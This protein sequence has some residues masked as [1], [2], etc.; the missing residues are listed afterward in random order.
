M[1][2]AASIESLFSLRWEGTVMMAIRPGVRKRMVMSAGLA[3]I[4]ALA[5]LASGCGNPGEGTVH[6]DPKAAARLGKPR[7][8]PPA[9]YARNKV[10][11]IGTKSRPRKDPAPK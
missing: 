11:P 1:I 6:V 4:A 3:L 7:G 10:A 5:V 2:A 9:A 8:L